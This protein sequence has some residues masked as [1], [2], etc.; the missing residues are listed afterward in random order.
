MGNKTRLQRSEMSKSKEQMLT[1]FNKLEI[2]G[3]ESIQQ[4]LKMSG[5]KRQKR[6]Q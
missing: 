4:K 3:V 2:I 6:K 1:R 5:E